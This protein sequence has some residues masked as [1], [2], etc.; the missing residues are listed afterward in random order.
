MKEAKPPST[1]AEAGVDISKENTDIEAIG[2]WVKKTFE[3]AS[4]GADFGHYANTISLGEWQLALATDGVGSKLLIAEMME[5]YDTIGIDC[6]A[7]NVNDLICIGMKPAAF[8]DYLATEK[9]L[10]AKKAEEIA[11]GLYE[12]C[13]ESN[14]PILG[15][16]MATLKDIVKGFDLAGTALGIGKKEQLIDGSKIKKGDSIIGIASNG[17]HSNGFTL[18][19]KVLL[20]SCS[21]TDELA[22]GRTLGEELLRP[23]EIYVKAIMELIEKVET[24]GVAH[25]TGSGFNKLRR[26]T[27]LGFEISFLPEIPL[28]FQLIKELGNIAWEE[29]FSTFNMGIGMA[30]IVSPEDEEKALETINQFNE[31]W[32]IGKIAD[33]G[34]IRIKPYKVEL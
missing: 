6:V 15:G 3:F 12:G 14:I 30:V 19:R 32:V 20:S 25:I 4:V 21:I 33:E 16:E 24:K 31:A 26:L 28:I 13:K 5:K 1:Y 23:T 11:K 17:I 9:P 8:V 29:M 27:S 7:M 18:A 10:G 34:K 2:K 22:N